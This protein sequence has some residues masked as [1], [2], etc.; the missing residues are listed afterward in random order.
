MKTA[1]SVTTTHKCITGTEKES[2]GDALVPAITIVGCGPGSRKYVSQAALEAIAE[3]TMIVG[4]QRLVDEF[5]AGKTA[6]AYTSV[7]D[8]LETIRR[9]S[10]EKIAVLV[11]GDPGFFSITA[12]IMRE[13][14]ASGVSIVP[15]IS[16]ITYAFGR[17]GIA[18]HDAVFMSAHKTIPVDFGQKVT[19]SVKSGILTSPSHTPASLVAQLGNNIAAGRRF[20]VGERLS[21]PDEKLCGYNYEQICRLK[22]DD[23]SVLVIIKNEEL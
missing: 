18:W 12:L 6:L 4:A 16:S 1:Q 9:N 17:L 11:T 13:F 2:S 19:A 20:F 5:G 7:K 22:A 3:A 10:K 8:T 21:Y 15:G 14:S 23:L